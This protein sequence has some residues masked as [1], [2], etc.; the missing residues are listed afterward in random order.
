MK[1]QD[2]QDTI[3][4]LIKDLSDANPYRLEVS[5]TNQQDEIDTLRNVLELVNVIFNIIIVITMF[6]CFF[7]LSANMSANLFEQSKEIAVLRAIGVTKS[8]IKMLYFYE[9]MVL[10]SASSILG[11]MIG[12]MVG[13]TMTKQ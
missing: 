4:A 11:M 10:V 3:K 6:L 7:A 8:R 9:A 2:D 1:N 12:T 13:F 5:Y